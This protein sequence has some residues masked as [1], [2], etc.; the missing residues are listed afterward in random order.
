MISSAN[1]SKNAIID[2]S[3]MLKEG[4]V[5]FEALKFDYDK[6]KEMESLESV[7]FGW[8][9]VRQ[10][11]KDGNEWKRIVTEY[12][13]TNFPDSVYLQ[14]FRFPYQKID[15]D[16]KLGYKT[17]YVRG[18]QAKFRE[19]QKII[20]SLEDKRIATVKHA[21]ITNDTILYRVEYNEHDHRI[22]INGIELTRPDFDSEN[23]RFIN[24]VN[25][26]PN[27]KITTDDLKNEGIKK[28]ITKI[29]SELGF[30]GTTKDL[31]FPGI[32]S[33]SVKFV[34]PITYDYAQK[35]KLPILKIKFS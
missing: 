34:N 22:S 10:H 4:G 6:L 21:S 27:K 17:A 18:F 28:P 23:D 14:Q 24:Y 3:R 35:N 8:S 9:L 2:L 15:P 26:H 19:L 25:Q 30:T 31:F 7:V 11:V 20:T 29:V 33:N 1:K 16:E 13:A 32:S 12:L 5:I